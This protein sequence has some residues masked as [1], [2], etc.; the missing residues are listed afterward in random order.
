MDG[1]EKLEQV[2]KLEQAVKEKRDSLL[3]AFNNVLK[4]YNLS[5]LG[6]IDIQFGLKDGQ[7]DNK[8]VAILE[9]FDAILEQNGL[10]TLY[11]HS[12]TLSKQVYFAVP[13]CEIWVYTDGSWVKVKVICN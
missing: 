8:G 4:K 2:K 9:E 10:G 1:I 12:F 11:T 7:V 6:V 5:E 3:K 13:S